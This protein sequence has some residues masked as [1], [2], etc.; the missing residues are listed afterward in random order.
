LSRSAHNVIGTGATFR[1]GTV[2][3][4][5]AME[6]DSEIDPVIDMT[7]PGSDT[8]QADG[9]ASQLSYQDSLESHVT[10]DVLDEGYSP[11]DFLPYPDVPTPAE[12][13]AGEGLSRRLAEEEPDIGTDI[14]TDDDWDDDEGRDDDGARG[15]GRSGRLAIADE[16]DEP[17][18]DVIADDLGI[19][20]GAASAEEA[21]VHMIDDESGNY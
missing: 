14:D 13:R 16:G 6:R 20:G 7:A 21:A 18:N 10:D 5:N 2:E 17:V 15:G 11:P 3:G 1:C 8:D 12:E 4:A 19:A 9:S